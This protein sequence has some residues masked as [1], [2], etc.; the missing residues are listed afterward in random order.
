MRERIK[1][2][3]R[4]RVLRRYVVVGLAGTGVQYV[5]GWGQVSAGVAPVVASS[6]AFVGAHGFNYTM[7]HRWT[8]R[9]S[10]AHG[11]SLPA[12]A[13]LG[14]AGI[15]VNGAVM[16]LLAECLRWHYFWAQSFAVAAVVVCNAVV[17]RLIF[18]PSRA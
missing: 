16:W 6:V 5:L 15:Q 3:W 11:R 13:V 10:V 18:R 2:A 17:S 12:Y 9:S 14:L 8:Y 4:S 7:H 1:S